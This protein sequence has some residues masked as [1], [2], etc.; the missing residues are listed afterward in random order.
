LKSQ[1][2]IKK[3]FKCESVVSN[4]C[5]AIVAMCVG[6]YMPCSPGSTA[7]TPPGAHAVPAVEYTLSLQVYVRY[8]RETFRVCGM[9]VIA[10]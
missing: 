10:A 6:E 4:S 9:P 7:C 2:V 1:S 3:L 8:R 5:Y